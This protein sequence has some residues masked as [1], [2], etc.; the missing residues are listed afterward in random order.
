MI[1]L[2]AA[3]GQV[4]PRLLLYPG[5]LF[6]LGA[7]WMLCRW[8]A[9]VSRQRPA[10]AGPV[11][12]ASL[13]G[14]LPP[15]I[16]LALMP[17]A[18]ARGFPYG[19][20]LVVALGLLEWPY[21]RRGVAG[22]GKVDRARL[23][24]MY[25]P[26]LLAGGGMAEANASLGLSNLL[27]VPEAPVARALLLASALLWLASLPQLLMNPCAAEDDHSAGDGSKEWP[28]ASLAARLRALGLV[29]IGMLALLG[30]ASVRSEPWLT[31]TQAGWLLP[32]LVGVVTALL[33]GVQ[34]R[35]APWLQRFYVG[36][37]VVLV[38]VLLVSKSVAW[39]V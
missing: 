20:D 8:L 37:L 10:C 24:R 39:L 33:L 28:L 3:L 18:P 34:L 7:S 11:M 35:M 23:L 1:E 38:V 27:T 25:G 14:L 19:L 29:L 2:L 13:P 5:G 32:P 9:W 6:A 21:L 16:V 12:L 26:L 36:L 22:I 15:M 30:F 31:A 17:L 4:W